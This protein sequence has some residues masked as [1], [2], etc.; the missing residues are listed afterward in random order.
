MRTC[1]VDRPRGQPLARI[2]GTRV[3]IIEK[4]KLLA[5]FDVTACNELRP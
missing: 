5:W 4:V 3:A 1:K 2:E